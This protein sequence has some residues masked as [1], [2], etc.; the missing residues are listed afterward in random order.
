MKIYQINSL[1]TKIQKRS[2]IRILVVVILLIFVFII[3]LFVLNYLQTGKIIVTTKNKAT[4]IT[5]NTASE[6]NNE[7]ALKESKGKLSARLKPGNYYLEASDEN[8]AKTKYVTIEKGKTIKLEINTETITTS[9]PVISEGSSAIAINTTYL[10]FLAEDGLLNS[11]DRNNNVSLLSPIKFADAKFADANYGFAQ[12]YDNNLFMV[13]NNNVT[14]F[15]IP[16][17]IKKTQYAIVLSPSKTLYVWT[18][19]NVYKVAGMNYVNIF[20]SNESN[21]PIYDV[22]AGNST[23]AV[24]IDNQSPEENEEGRDLQ[25]IKTIKILNDGS[26]VNTK[27]LKLDKAAMS[28]DGNYIATTSTSGTQI[29]DNQFNQ[30]ITLLNTN[31]DNLIWLNGS[32]LIYSIIDKIISFDINSKESYTVTQ[33]PFKKTIEYISVNDDKTALYYESYNKRS[34]PAMSRASLIKNNVPE[35]LINAQYFLPKS[36]V[37]CTV[38]LVNF[39]KPTVIMTIPNTD[40]EPNCK[41]KTTEYFIQS[42]LKPSDYSY[43]VINNNLDD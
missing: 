15:Y 4:I 27:D 30:L 40:V 1:F 5:I 42:G 35:Y 22:L 33:S 34:E 9:E 11:I 18:S 29:Y 21:K 14:P 2:F 28:A 20:T 32:R 36:F 24:I 13:Q 31:V 10:S 37:S 7:V 3:L 16:D 23:V 12:D 25:T 41:I 19:R 17:Y 6:N 43:S 26:I 38:E 8:G 39:I